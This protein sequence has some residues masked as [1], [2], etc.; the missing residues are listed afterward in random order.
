M[1][2]A[3]RVPGR[4]L[5]Y[6]DWLRFLVV[7]LLAPFHAAISFTGKGVVYVYDDPV[8]D[9]ILAGTNRGEAG[10]V[11]MRYFTVL[12]D[13]WGMQLLFFIA[14]VAAALALR[15]RSP[16]EFV[17]E[18]ANR[19]LIPLLIGTLLVVPVQSWLRALDFGRFDGGLVAFYPHFFN[20]VNLG[21]GSSGNLDWGHL[22]FLAYLFVLSAITVP[23]MW[24]LTRNDGVMRFAARVS[25]GAWI[26]VPG[27]WIALLE[28]ALRPGWPGYFDLV[29]DWAN[30]T[31]YLSFVALG[32]VAGREQ[33]LLEAM[34]RNRFLALALGTGAFACRMAVYQLVPVPDG[35]SG[36]N[37]LTQAFRGLAAY[38]LV[39]AAIGF[40]RRYLV[41]ES[42][43]L[44]VARDL[45][46][47]LYVL[48][49]VPVMAATYL[50]L[51]SGLSVWTRWGIAVAAAWLS[52]AI[53]TAIARYVPLLRDLLTIRPPTSGDAQ[54]DSVVLDGLDE[55]DIEVVDR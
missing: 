50:L 37:I 22:W 4:R 52:V 17:G 21:P 8:R 39:V 42:P 2:E 38:A 53:F 14:G 11:A 24:R 51:G 1:S 16:G 49:Y 13:N 54:P 33:S 26:L 43:A 19:L 55:H 32:F 25:R 31:V 46:F 27:L 6:L 20:G 28:A 48:H 12:L 10:P 5:P 35:Y 40:G 18:R 36:A 45:S 15:R 29:H 3:A 9:A 47:P 7:L 44:G 30:V 34:E 41:R 23:L